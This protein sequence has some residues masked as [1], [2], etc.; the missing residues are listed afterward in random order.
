M[1]IRAKHSERQR[2]L[3]DARFREDQAEQGLDALRERLAELVVIEREGMVAEREI[4]ALSQ[5]ASQGS[6]YRDQ[7]AE[8]ALELRQRLA[9]ARATEVEL[10][11]L[12]REEARLQALLAQSRMEMESLGVRRVLPIVDA[13]AMASTCGAAWSE[14]EGEGCA[15]TCPRCALSVYHDA[16]M[17]QQELGLAFTHAYGTASSRVA[18]RR[19]DGM[20]LTTDCPKG[21]QMGKL[22]RVAMVVTALCAIAAILRVAQVRFEEAHPARPEPADY[23]CGFSGP[24]PPLHARDRPY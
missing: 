7:S 2:G 15:R 16:A 11:S 1:E 20:L 12:R 22:T 18:F 23:S 19:R 9:V 3:T 24:C 14:M 8:R 10:A 5:S 17:T 6:A 4:A 21:R 13:V